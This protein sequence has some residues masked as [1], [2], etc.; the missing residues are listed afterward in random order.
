MVYVRCCITNTEKTGRSTESFRPA[1]PNLH[2]SIG[3]LVTWAKLWS[4]LYS[5]Y[6][7]SRLRNGV[8]PSLAFLFSSRISPRSTTRL[9]FKLHPT[10]SIFD[11]Q[12]SATIPWWRTKSERTWSTRD[13]RMLYMPKQRA[14]IECLRYHKQN[15]R[16]EWTPA[17]S[18]VLV[19]FTEK[20]FP[21]LTEWYSF[22][23]LWAYFFFT[24]GLFLLFIFHERR[25]P[26]WRRGSTGEF[27]QVRDAN[28]IC[29]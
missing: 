21:F 8:Y 14:I 18:G 25:F 2:G 24:Q 5:S 23:L 15:S 26:K 6:P 28:K 13:G 29:K 10:K 16:K 19:A 9:N 4:R 17:W 27:C 7:L 11:P 3:W 20:F 22:F 12:D 1:N